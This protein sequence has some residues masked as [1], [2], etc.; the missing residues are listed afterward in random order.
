MAGPDIQLAD[1]STVK[2]LVDQIHSGTSLLMIL[3]LL[4]QYWGLKP[5]LKFCVKKALRSELALNGMPCITYSLQ[6][7]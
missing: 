6:V 7:L 4:G 1:R 2:M 3:E 5:S